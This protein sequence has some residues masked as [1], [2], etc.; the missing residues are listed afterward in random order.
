MGDDVRTLT[1]RAFIIVS[2]S[3]QRA[4]SVTEIQENIPLGVTI[5]GK[6]IGLYRLEGTFYAIDDICPHQCAPLSSGYLDG[7]A[8]ECPL[9]QA[10]FHVPVC[11]ES[12]FRSIVIASAIDG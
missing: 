1:E 10:L 2:A 11:W 9:H 12:C 3:W 7:D 4:A 5:G 8:I 6:S